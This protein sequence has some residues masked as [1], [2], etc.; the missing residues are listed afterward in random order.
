[1]K[2]QTQNDNIA[3][4]APEIIGLSIAVEGGYSFSDPIRDPEED[5]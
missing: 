1:M 2:L 3:Y 4:S 5:W